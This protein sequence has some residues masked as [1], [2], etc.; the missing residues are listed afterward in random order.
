MRKKQLYA[1][2]LAGALAAGSA[3]PSVWAAEETAATETAE[4]GSGEASGTETSGQ[5]T[6]EAPADG[7]A[8]TETPTEPTQIPAEPTQ[9]PV[10]TAEPTQAPAADNTAADTAAQSEATPAPE[11]TEAQNAGAEVTPTPAQTNTGI[12]IKTTSGDG[13][14]TVNYYQTLQEAVDAAQNASGSEATVI[15]ITETLALSSTVTVSEKKVC[16]T[17][18]ADVTIGR[19]T[20]DSG[21]PFDGDMF[22]VAGSGGELQFA[23]RDGYS[24]TVDGNTG[25]G[26]DVLSPGSIVNV[27][28]GSAFGLASGV[29]M[30]G[31][32]SSAS[33]G[34]ITNDGGSIVLQGGSITGNKGSKGAV[35]TNTDVAVQGSVSVTGNTGANL[36]LDGSSAA[37]VT[38][39]MTGSSI[40]LTSGSAADQAV[41]LKAGNS[42]DGTQISQDDFKAAVGQF[43]Y[44]TA[45][46]SITLAED[47]LTAVLKQES[48]ATPT[49]SAAPSQSPAP[50]AVPS[51]TPAPTGAPSVTPTTSPSFLTYQSG[52]LK[53]VDHN[54]ISV[55]M[56]TTKDCKW[57][58]FFVNADTS[59]SEIQQMYDS[60]RAVNSAGANTTF[61]IKVENVPE[62]DSWLVVAAKPTTGNVQ[63]RVLKLN[64]TWFKNKRPAAATSVTSRAPRTYAVT[65]S[66]VTGLEEPLKFYPSTFYEFRVTGAGQNDSAPYVSGD[67]RWIPMYWSTAQNP[68][69][70]QKNTTWRIGS[71]SGI[72][73]AATYNMYIFFKKQ[74]Y[75]GSEWTDTDVIEYMVTQFQ[76][77]EITADE[78]AELSITPG[79]GGYGTDGSGVDLAATEGASTKS[80]DSTS[81]SAVSTADESP[82]GTMSA[83][84]ALSLAAGGYILVR[85]RKKE[86]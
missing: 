62:E 81:R 61:T 34:A 18:A 60:S 49:P 79:G 9:T 72:T 37:V 54:T 78:I 58:Y 53:W 77:A 84:A 38:G 57:Y 85:K 45:D 30:T 65:E 7:A 68:T 43:S 20:T 6:G 16:I 55:G 63:M 32:N 21:A 17:A 47:G 69:D 29:T 64:S 74:V 27:G 5:Q 82:I 59:T 3:S 35:Y 13:T 28:A 22:S 1:I 42:E 46:F 2:L 12:S 44:D 11:E 10:Q 41:V 73:Q 24:L 14:E 48:A 26:E 19:G 86:A 31:S 25:Q 36:Y 33:G 52:S 15:E 71:S 50:T 76:S 8:V 40:A 70:S 4:N 83:L 56:S 23:V 66:T 80:G 75:N 67:E 51:A 39:A